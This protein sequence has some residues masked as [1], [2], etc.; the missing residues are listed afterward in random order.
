MRLLQTFESYVGLLAVA[1][2]AQESMTHRRV[3]RLLHATWRYYNLASPQIVAS[4]SEQRAMLEK[5]IQAFVKLASWK[6]VNVHAL[7]QSAQRTHHNLYKIVRKFRDVLRQPITAHLQPKLAGDTECKPMEID[8]NTNLPVATEQPSF[9]AK[10]MALAASHL[11]DLDRTYRK[12]DSFIT[13]RIQRSIQLHSAVAV[14]DL[15]TEIIVTAKSL[16]STSI[17]K[18]LSTP[19]RAKQ[20]KALLVRKRKAWNDLLKE[21]K[22]GGLSVNSKPEVLRRQGDPLWIREQPVLLTTAAHSIPTARVD[23]YFDRLHAALPQLR[24]SLSDHHSDVTTR[25]LQRGIM[26]LESGF[27]LALEARSQYV[28]LLSAPFSVLTMCLKCSL[29]G[30]LEVYAKFNQLSHRLHTLSISKTTA[31]DLPL[32]DEISR[33]R[34]IACKLTDALNEVVC[35]LITNDDLQS[36]SSL[37]SLILEDVRTTATAASESRDRLFE[38]MLDLDVNSTLILVDSTSFVLMIKRLLI[39][40]S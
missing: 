19:K 34:T 8:P 5:E 16:A 36:T 9:P 37:A 12:F 11:L 39:I 7:K 31:F 27:A 40:Y 18:D 17:G 32:F 4:L 28:Y 35:A 24:T 1:S 3:Q 26:L 2:K 22:R 33:F 10:D 29:A 30:T 21:L 23:L 25:E 14:D 13:N 20:Q 38:L 6:D 15:A